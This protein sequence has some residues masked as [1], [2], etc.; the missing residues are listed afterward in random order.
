MIDREY[1]S[2]W[3]QSIPITQPTMPDVQDY[4]DSVKDIFASKWLTNNGKYHRQLETRVAEYCECP[5]TSLVNNG[6]MAILLAIAA[7]ELEDG[8][9]IITTP[10]TFAAS[11]HSIDWLGYDPVFA[12]IDP[13][14]GNI[15]PKSVKDRITPK[16]RAVLAVHVYGTP[17]DHEAL[18]EVCSERNIPI[19]Y[20]AAHAFGVKVGGE[21]IFRLGDASST[22]FHATKLFSTVEGGAV[23]VHN[24]EAKE[25]VDKLKNFGILNENK[26]QYSGLNMKQSEMHSAFGLLLIDSVNAEI[27]KRAEIA[28]IYAEGLSDIDSVTI[29]TKGEGFEPNWAYYTILID[30][31]K[32]GIGRDQLYDELK[33]LNIFTR[34]YF[35]PLTSR[36]PKYENLPSAAMVPVAQQWEKQVLCLPIYGALEKAAAKFIVQSIRKIIELSS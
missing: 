13:V 7:L 21:N 15:C 19:I 11:T 35:Y 33:N 9:E 17:C 32:A 1:L 4:I 5:H 23:F 31:E 25:R 30:E 10:F 3:P 27:A 12:D 36:V 6:T 8:G 28:K 24:A 22:S 20:D 34:R 29:V 16:T 14:T 2:A 18:S 26:I